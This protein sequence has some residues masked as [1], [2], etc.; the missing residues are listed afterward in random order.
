MVIW[1]GDLVLLSFSQM[2]ITN[3]RLQKIVVYEPI[4]QNN[5]SRKYK[6]KVFIKSTNLS[7]L[8]IR[9]YPKDPLFIIKT[10]SSSIRNNNEKNMKENNKIADIRKDYTKFKLDI[11]SI[12][13]NPFE[14]FDKWFNEAL[15]SKLF[16]EPTAF[17]LST[18]GKNL[19]PSSR[20]VLLKKYDMK[21]FVFYT[22]YESRKGR[23]LLENPFAS[24]LFFY[25]K[26]E[27]Q[28]RIEGKVE[29]LSQEESD[30]YFQTRPKKSKL[31]AWA[32]NQ[33]EVLNSRFT[34]MRKFVGFAMKYPIR[35]PIPDFWGG[36]RI[37]PNGF[38]FW[39]GRE[40]RLHDR[41]RYDLKSG[42]WEIKRLSP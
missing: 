13:K 36:Y 4:T 34:L 20:I 21:G 14:Q 33:S 17:T 29:K 28:I 23:E 42:L 5:K 18:V 12:E 9:T 3:I 38:E 27:R 15:E 32:S 2:K 26:F 22:N 6:S 7:E 1:C 24:M 30:E 19:K 16:V 39:Q 37:V 11:D 41:L 25:D 10:T 8:R 35:V 31:G 40:S